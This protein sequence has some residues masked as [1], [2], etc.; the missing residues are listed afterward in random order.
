M[1]PRNFSYMT[2]RK[3]LFFALIGLW[4]AIS[5]RAG[6]VTFQVDMS[7]QILIDA[8]NPASGHVEVRGPFNN[9]TNGAAWTLAPSQGN[10]EIYTGTFNIAGAAGTAIEYKFWRTPDNWETTASNRSFTLETNAQ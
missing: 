9:W 3:L 7:Y 1:F 6:Q 2:L 4:A 8:F 5:S 10:P